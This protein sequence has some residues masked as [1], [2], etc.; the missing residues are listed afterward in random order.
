MGILG[1]NVPSDGTIPA[2]EL[3]DIYPNG[4]VRIVGRREFEEVQ[5]WYLKSLK[6]SGLKVWLCIA[7]ESIGDMSFKDAAYYY[8]Y[9]YSGFLDY[10]QVGN[11][12]DHIS[13]SSWTLS[14][15]ELFD[16]VYSFWSNPLIRDI[17]IILG[18]AV[19]GDAER[20]GDITRTLSLLDGISIHPYGQR[21]SESHVA[22]SGDFGVAERLFDTYQSKLTQLGFNIKMY[23]SEYGVSSDQV[24]LDKQAEYVGEFALM[25]R[26]SKTIYAGIH[27]CQHNYLG[28]GVRD[29]NEQI[30]PKLYNL[31]KS[32]AQGQVMAYSFA[33]GI[34]DKADA[35]KARGIDVGLPLEPETY[36]YPNSPYSYQFTTKGKFEYSKVANIVH[37][38]QG[39]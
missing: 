28:F 10:L 13:N 19:S 30:K 36:P 38:F 33:F 21:A 4:I 29:R 5:Y 31:L 15:D 24:S 25:L 37:F 22:P 8:L 12:W 3:S 2:S 35:L 32:A 6:D 34:K 39:A 14:P 11:E 9:R 18:G 16:L 1:T 26:N 17:P 20:L 7:K 23:V 27:F